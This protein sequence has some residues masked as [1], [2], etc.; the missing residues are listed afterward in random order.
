M[1]RKYF[2]TNGIRGVVGDRITPE[3][4]LKMSSAIASHM[5]D[6]GTIIVGS[7]SRFSSP[8]LKK[9][10]T[11]SFLSKGMEVI[12]IGTVPTP[13][14]QF[15]VT[16]LQVNMGIMVTASHNPPEFN[17]IKVIDFDGIEIDIQKQIQIEQLFE[18]EKFQFIKKIENKDVVRMDVST[19]YMDQIMGL[20]D[21]DSIAKKKLSAVVDGGNGVGS[22]IT[23]YLLRKLG[24]KVISLNCQLDGAFPGRGVEPIPEKLRVM[25]S[26]ATDIGADFSIAHD[27]D[28]DRAI[29][30]DNKGQIHFGDKSIALFEKYVLSQSN[31]KKFVT[32]ISSSSVMVDVIEEEG[33]EIFW[34]PVGCIY[35]SRKMI[36]K[37]CILG[38]EENGGL[39]YGPHQSVRDGMM[40]AALMAEI[41]SN[42]EKR[43]NNM[44]SEFP[45]YFQRKSKLRCSDNIKEDVMQFIVNNA[46]KAEEIITIDGIKL[47]YSDGWIL[48]RPSGTEPIF[49]IFVEAKIAEK[50]DI[51]MKKGLELVKKA[52]EKYSEQP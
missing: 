43:L 33:G 21:I 26:I 31:N 24:V 1:K 3:F 48:I 52:I 35:V 37:D 10:I 18:E 12:D 34:T 47:I 46:E 19:E 25:N 40:A 49:R 45:H 22:L 9:I 14:L 36:E 11:A 2:G 6:K 27:G 4:V 17:G 28:A 42:S 39:F 15:A 30:G 44:L 20:V 16:L 51:L 32:P 23:P 38:G 13:L 29:F 5:Q 7:D 8:E 41:L 50:A